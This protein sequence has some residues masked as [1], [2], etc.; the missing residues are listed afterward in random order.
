MSDIMQVQ[1]PKQKYGFGIDYT[2]KAFDYA[3]YV[4][5]IENMKISDLLRTQHKGFVT[6]QE[7]L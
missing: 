2:K 4:D 1:D 7:K 6:S 3:I 5:S